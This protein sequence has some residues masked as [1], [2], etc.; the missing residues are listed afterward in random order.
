MLEKSLD[1]FSCPC[2]WAS[3]PRHFS[4][5]LELGGTLHALPPQI[6]TLLVEGGTQAV[7]ASEAFRGKMLMFSLSCQPLIF[8]LVRNV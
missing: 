6:M 5:K 7:T 3:V 1:S 8:E 4:L 2:A